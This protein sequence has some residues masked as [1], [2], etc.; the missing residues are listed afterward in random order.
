MCDT[1]VKEAG[2]RRK[3]LGGLLREESRGAGSIGFGGTEGEF[4]ILM[5]AYLLSQQSLPWFCWSVRIDKAVFGQS[6]KR[7]KIC[8]IRES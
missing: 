5:L 7:G 3:P 2:D 6:I 8:G 4:E 1:L